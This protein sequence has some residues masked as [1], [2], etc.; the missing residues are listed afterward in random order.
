MVRYIEGKVG[1]VCVV[2]TVCVGE[3]YVWFGECASVA[4]EGSCRWAYSLQAAVSEE[5][6]VEHNAI[7][8]GCGAV[9]SVPSVEVTQEVDRGLMSG[10][11]VEV[12]YWDVSPSRWGVVGGYNYWT[13]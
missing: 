6:I 7:V 4:A 2:I 9:G 13:K 5:F 3:C 8:V 12:C 11:P 1:A 10:K